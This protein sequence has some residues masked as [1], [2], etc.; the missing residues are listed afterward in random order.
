MADLV[1]LDVLT[2]L[3]M[4]AIAQLHFAVKIVRSA[5]GAL[6]DLQAILEGAQQPLGALLQFILDSDG[7]EGLT[8]STVKPALTTLSKPTRLKSNR[9][10]YRLFSAN[11]GKCWTSDML[12]MGCG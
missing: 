5:G 7:T 10:S 9:R 12:K 6:G 1:K 4:P 3:A 8:P 2:E 11:Y